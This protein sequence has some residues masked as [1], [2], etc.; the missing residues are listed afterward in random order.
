MVKVLRNS[1]I[2]GLLLLAPLGVT[3]FVL[4]FL[5]SQIG[6]PI[7]KYVFWFVEE[8]TRNQLNI[9]FDILA[10]VIA[11]AIITLLGLVSNY[12]LGRYLIRFFEEIMDRLPFIN[13][14]YRTVKQIVDTFSVQKKAVFQ[15]AVLVEFPKAGSYAVGFITDNSRG[16][17]QQKT[18]KDLLNI[19]VPTSPIPTSGFLILVPEAEVIKLDMSIADAMKVVIS[20]GT[21]VPPVSPSETALPA[22]SHSDIDPA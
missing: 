2:S 3:F 13:A 5:V 22:Q 8:S 1:F 11:V 7:S 18:G 19:F 20:G 12:F 21:V 9:L 6:T 4:H 16:E 15:Q 14:I 10:T 17:P